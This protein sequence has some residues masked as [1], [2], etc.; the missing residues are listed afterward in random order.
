MNPSTLFPNFPE[1]VADTQDTVLKT[2]QHSD[3]HQ[4]KYPV[5]LSP[6]EKPARSAAVECFENL[7]LVVNPIE[8]LTLRVSY[9]G[10]AP[11]DLNTR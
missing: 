10:T 3:R 5:W 4:V 8:N 9:E 2:A 7:A 6:D 11:S 1:G